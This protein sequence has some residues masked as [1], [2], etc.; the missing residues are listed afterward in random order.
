MI[1]MRHIAAGCRRSGGSVG[2]GA[3]GAALHAAPNQLY[4]ILT[5]T[6]ACGLQEQAGLSEGVRQGV[7]RCALRAV[8]ACA[9]APPLAAALRHAGVVEALQVSKKH[10][11]LSIG[12]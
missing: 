2:G 11:V 8:N 6:I 9:A 4:I 7:R 3:G 10:T 12:M 5:F 1:R